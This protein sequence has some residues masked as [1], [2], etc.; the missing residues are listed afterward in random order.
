MLRS[1]RQSRQYASLK[2]THTHSS[3]IAFTQRFALSINIAFAYAGHLSFSQ[4]FAISERFTFLNI[5]SDANALADSVA[6]IFTRDVDS[7]SAGPIN[8]SDNTYASD[9]DSSSD[10]SEP[11]RESSGPLVLGRKRLDGS[12]ADGTGLK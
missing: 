10:F 12:A 8:R 2:N 9:N 11:D 3:R 5:D 1:S 6:V 4:C 7:Q